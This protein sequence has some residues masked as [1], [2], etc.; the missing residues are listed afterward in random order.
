[1]RANFDG[2]GFWQA[3]S[4]AVIARKVT[5]RQVSKATG[6]SA[7]T[8]SRM[9]DGARHPDAASLA[10]LSAWAGLNPADFVPIEPLPTHTVDGLMQMIAAHAEAEYHGGRLGLK[11]CTIAL[12]LIRIYA[13]KLLEAAP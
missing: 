6:V 7:S 9:R 11:Q 2:A 10:A 4:R 13:R 12:Q 5:W 8:L 1:M 3:L